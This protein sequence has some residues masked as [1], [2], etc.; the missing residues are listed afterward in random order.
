MHTAKDE[1]YNRG[2]EWWLMTEAKK[3]EMKRLTNLL[4]IL[5]IY[6]FVLRETLTSNC[7]VSLGLIHPG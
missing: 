2:Y 6:R 4:S 7:M 3:V 1:N 5:Q